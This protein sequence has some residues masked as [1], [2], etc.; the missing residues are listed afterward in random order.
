VT[1]SA[2]PLAGRR[3]RVEGRRRVDGVACLMVGLGD[4]TAVTIAVA[5]TSAAGPVRGAEAS[6]GAV[7]SV[8][9]LRRLRGLLEGRVGDGNGT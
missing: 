7:V 3:L 5:A 2:H 4:G 6:V 9:G 8:V 1:A